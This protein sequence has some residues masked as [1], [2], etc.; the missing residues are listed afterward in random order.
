MWYF[1]GIMVP[2]NYVEKAKAL[3]QKTARTTALIIVPLGAAVS[4]HATTVLPT[5]DFSCTYTS[6]GESGGCSGGATQ[7]AA[8]GGVEGVGLYTD[9]PIYL[10]TSSGSSTITLSTANY[11]LTGSLSGGTVLP[12]SWD[13]ILGATVDPSWSLTFT[14]YNS[15][16]AIGS[17]TTSGSGPAGTISGS[18][19]LSG[20]IY[21]GIEGCCND[22]ELQV[23]LTTDGASSVDIPSGLTMN[24]VPPATSTVPEP[25]TT[26]LL[27][28][29]LAWMGWRLRKVR[30]R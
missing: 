29:G 8:S 20:L 21:G 22:I 3:I 11:D 28:A 9:G 6:N 15:G 12:V 27:A 4:A 13:F 30:R 23:Q 26:G 25:A 10:S 17:F 16:A 5:S 7:L 1:L 24:F 18:G 2:T 19:D 14:I